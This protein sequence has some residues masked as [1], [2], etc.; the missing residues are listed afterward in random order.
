M[1]VVD[2]I[3]RKRAGGRLEDHEIA[4]LIADYSQDRVPSYQMAALAMAICFQGL[5]RQELVAWT[6]AMMR[7]G[8][9]LEWHL[10]GPVVDKHSTGGVGDKVS[11]AL[12][13]VCAA[14]GLYVP[15]ISGRGLGH[16]G[17]TLDKLEAIPGFDVALSPTRLRA[18]VARH[19]MAIVGQTGEIVPADRR[20]YALRDVTATVESV[21]LIASS[22]MSKKLAEG[23][24]GLVL[25][26]KV[27]SG[28]FMP[29]V[30]RARALSQAMIGLGRDMGVDTRVL[31]TDMD[32]PLGLT[33]GN[34]LELIEAIETLQGGGPDDLV[35]LVCTLAAEMMHLA[36]VEQDRDH[37]AYIARKLLTSGEAFDAFRDVVAAQGGDVSTLDDPS[38]LPRA[39]AT[40]AFGAQADGFVSGFEC[41]QVGLLAMVLGAGRATAED[42]IDHG[43]GFVLHKKRGDAVRK[44]EALVTIHHRPEQDLSPIFDGLSRA[45]TLSPTPPPSVPLI[46][47]RL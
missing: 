27:G 31:I 11:L 26:V 43:V 42:T 20:L 21:P 15:M 3:G 22:I 12:A 29:D 1:R 24:D 41:A 17:G 9:V 36:G 47:D 19:R 2:L 16:T 5:D 7:S 13:P 23:L 10:D 4:E 14:A 46:L 18:L 39:E 33:V 38:K 8:E 34:S 32:Q 28:A 45:I 6:R 40:T 35:A 25:D 30:E 44:G 37:G